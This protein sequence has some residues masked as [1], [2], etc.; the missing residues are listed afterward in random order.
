MQSQS[1][2]G[3]AGHDQT[4]KEPQGESAQS[5]PEA[6]SPTPAAEQLSSHNEAQHE[7][8]PSTSAPTPAPY[9]YRGHRPVYSWEQLE[10]DPKEGLKPLDLGSEAGGLSTEDWHPCRTMLPRSRSLQRCTALW[11]AVDGTFGQAQALAKDSDPADARPLLFRY[12]RG[13]SALS[14]AELAPSLFPPLVTPQQHPLLPP[15]SASPKEEWAQIET[16]RQAHA[17][18]AELLVL[19]TTAMR[20]VVSIPTAEHEG[21]L[22]SG[23]I[24]LSAP[25]KVVP[26]AR[27][28]WEVAAAC[29]EDSSC[30]GFTP[31]GRLFR[32]IGVGMMAS[33]HSKS[34]KKLAKPELPRPVYDQVRQHREGLPERILLAAEDLAKDG[35]TD[36]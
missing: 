8:A 19:M 34:E 29:D 36:T 1:P 26:D 3:H 18:E 12:L 6:V 16:M 7:T 20:H 28:Q 22:R 11:R 30:E 27:H 21:W 9:T 23:G 33:F 4:P 2:P 25:Y 32:W 10:L 35:S 17:R 31:D 24:P 13:H 5:K 15:A 14:R